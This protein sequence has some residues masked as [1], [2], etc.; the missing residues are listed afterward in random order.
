AQYILQTRRFSEISSYPD[1]ILSLS[2]RRFTL[3]QA[4]GSE[5][6]RRRSPGRRMV[7]LAGRCHDELLVDGAEDECED[8]KALAS[9][10]A[11]FF[12]MG[13]GAESLL[14]TSGLE[15]RADRYGGEGIFATRDLPLG[16]E[17]FIPRRYAFDAAVAR[18]TRLG[19][20]LRPDLG[21]T[22]EDA[23]LAVLAEARLPSS[24]SPFRPYV[25]TLPQ[26]A[27]DAASWPAIARRMLVGTDLG[28][29]LVVAERDLVELV[30]RLHTVSSAAHLNLEDLRWAR[31]IMLSRRFPELNNDGSCIGASGMWGTLGLLVPIFDLFNHSGDAPCTMARKHVPTE[32]AAANPE[33]LVLSNPSPLCAGQEAMNNYGTDKSNEEL[34]AMYGFACANGASDGVSLLVTASPVA[35]PIRCF[36]GAGGITEAVWATL[37]AGA[38][39]LEAEA[40]PDAFEREVLSKL[41]R[42]L[43]DKLIAL[44]AGEPSYD[45][46]CDDGVDVLAGYVKHY[47][48][49]LRRVL[50]RALKECD[51]MVQVLAEAESDESKSGSDDAEP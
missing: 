32:G 22:D 21:F 12:S 4:R 44:D 45:S 18:R 36:L 31:G 43:A 13:G 41:Y 40:D 24:E 19:S 34:L 3:V 9:E 5:R 48:K 27:P 37:T 8:L 46:G 42:A 6:G 38:T 25:S 17:L 16:F 29:A 47:R 11:A 28:A 26:A 7:A 15:R 50:T 51:A 10:L 35:E 14:S 1:P 20:A 2:S 33:Y 23:F 39:A 49:G 30:T